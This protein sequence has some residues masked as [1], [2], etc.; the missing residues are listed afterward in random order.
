MSIDLANSSIED[1]EINQQHLAI[2][3][4]NSY[5]WSRGYGPSASKLLKKIKKGVGWQDVNRARFKDGS[6]GNGAAMRAPIIS[7]CYPGSLDALQDS[8]VKTSE[9]THAHPWQ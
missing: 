3:F 7:M 9:I 6:Y 1:G 2:K 5:R 4:A 8:V